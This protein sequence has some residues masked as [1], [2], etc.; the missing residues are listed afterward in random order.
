M[1]FIFCV[2]HPRTQMG[3]PGPKGPF[4]SECDH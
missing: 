3:D 2:K 4:V 1:G